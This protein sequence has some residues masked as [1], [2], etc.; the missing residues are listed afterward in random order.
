MSIPKIIHYCWFGRGSKPELA[1]KCIESWKKYCPDYEIVEWN[2]DNFDVMSLPFTKEAY[3]SRKFAFVTDYVRLYAMYHHGGI[4]MDTD[5]EVRKSLDPFLKYQGF[6]GFEAPEKVPTGIMAGEKGFPLFAQLMEYYTD[7]HFLTPDGQM[8]MTT[9]VV[10][11]TEILTKLGLTLNGQFQIVDGF[12]LFPTDYFCPKD[13]ITRELHMTEN[14][15]VIHHFDGSWMTP[16]R[17]KELEEYR[18][19][20]KLFGVSTGERILLA[21]D[22]LKNEGFTALVRRVI[23]HFKK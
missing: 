23:D 14:T 17:K 12:A 10:I 4:Y 11:I 19:V 6:S 8:D 2:E 22:L 3:E 13:P 18:K 1:L 15:A 5:V 20:T 21:R 16:E 7:R 9:N